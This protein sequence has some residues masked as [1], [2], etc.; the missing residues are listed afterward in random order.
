MTSPPIRYPFYQWL[1]HGF[2]T[3]AVV[4]G[5]HGTVE[6]LPG[7]LGQLNIPGQIF[8]WEN[9]RIYTYMR[10]TIPRVDP[11]KSG[12]GYGVLISP[13]HT[14]LLVVLYKRI[15]CTARLVSEYR[16]QRKLCSQGSYLQE[17]CSNWGGCRLSI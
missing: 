16:N 10:L 1:Q 9:C 11:G 4:T 7:S 13:Q 14:A 6:W 12:R 15:N 8:S 3:D 5:M 17:D 2:Q